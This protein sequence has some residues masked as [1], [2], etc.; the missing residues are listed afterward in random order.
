MRYII[1]CVDFRDVPI[2]TFRTWDEADEW[3]RFMANYA[4]YPIENF[5]I[6]EEE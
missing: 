2:R 6:I 3:V 5:T 4:G 1:Y